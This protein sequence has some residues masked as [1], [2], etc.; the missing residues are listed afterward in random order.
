MKRVRRWLYN[1]IAS[2][3]LLLSLA[4]AYLWIKDGPLQTYRFQLTHQLQVLWR[5]G[6]IAFERHDSHT[7]IV[8]PKFDGSDYRPILLWRKQF[9]PS[10][11][12]GNH[13]FYIGDMPW[14]EGFPDGSFRYLGR[15]HW[16]SAPDWAFATAFLMFP[17]WA[18]IQLFRNHRRRRLRIGHCP[19][20]GYDLRASLNE[21]P[22]CGTAVPAGHKPTAV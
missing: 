10:N 8:A 21:C 17:L 11:L 5:H 2:L 4:M 1:V 3:S 13:G 14:V 20:C 16:I 9:P 19:V 7:P 22:E 15:S 6:G 12:H 18:L